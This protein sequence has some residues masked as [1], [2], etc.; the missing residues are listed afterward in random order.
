MKNGRMACLASWPGWAWC[1]T[2]GL[3]PQPA[4]LYQYVALA[5]KSAVAAI[6]KL[7]NVMCNESMAISYNV[8][9]NN[10]IMKA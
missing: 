6:Y 7:I 1:V 8:C 2:A 4:M 9:G 10:G 3:Q 5:S